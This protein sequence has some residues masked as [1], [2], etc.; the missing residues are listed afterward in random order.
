[1]LEWQ[2]AYRKLIGADVETALKRNVPADKNKPGIGYLAR[3]P[4]T[5]ACPQIRLHGPLQKLAEKG[6][7]E[8]VDFN[9]TQA[10]DY[11]I[12]VARLRNLDILIIQRNFAVAYSY[13]QLTKLLGKDR[14]LIVYEFDD[15]FDRL[16]EN[17]PGYAYYQNMKS[18]FEEYIKQADMV[19]VSTPVLKQYYSSL[20]A[21]TVVLP[22]TVNE[23]VWQ[24][25][26]DTKPKAGKATK[27]LFSGTLGHGTD[28][29]VI[30]KALQ[31]ILEEYGSKVELW[32]WGDEVPGLMQYKNVKMFESF[33]TDYREYARILKQGAFDFA[34]IP[35]APNEFNYAKSHIK[36]LEYSASGIAGVYSDIPAYKE[37]VRD[38]KTG[39]VVHNDP[40]AW[41]EAI[42]FM[43]ENPK[44]R[45]KIARAAY[46]EVWQKHTLSQNLHLW[47]E[48]YERLLRQ[49]QESRKL[50]KF[51]VVLLTWNRAQLLNLTLRALTEN[52]YFRDQTEIIV[53]DNGSTDDTP[54]VVKKYSV[55]KY[56]RKERNIGLELYKELFG[57]A[58]G[59][60]IIILD[61][62]VLDLPFAFDKTFLEYFAAFPEYGF[63]GLAVFRSEETNGGKP[64]DVNYTEEEKDGKII[65]RGPAGGWCACLSRAEFDRIN[66]FGDDALSMANTEDSI[67]NNRVIGFGKK[68]GII[69]NVRCF[70]ATGPFYSRKF[71]LLERDMEKYRMAGMQR[72]ANGYQN[73][74][75]KQKQPLVSVIIPL[76]NKLDLTRQCVRSIL[77]NTRYPR[78]EIIFVDN[79]S[80]DGTREYLKSI[81]KKE[82]RIRSILNETNAGFAIANNQGADEAN[83]KYILFLNN[84]TEVQPGWLR[85]LVDVA[86]DNPAVGAVGSKLLYPDGTLQHAGVVIVEDRQHGDPLLATHNFYKE[87]GDKPEA[88]RL[89][90][91][92]A[93]SAACLM[94]RRELF[95]QLGGFDPGFWNGYE[96]VDLCFRIAQEGYKLVYRPDSVVIHYESQSGEE[97]WKKVNQNIKRLHQKWLG[98]VQPDL[99]VDED[100]QKHITEQ[101][102]IRPYYLL[103]PA[104]SPKM[105]EEK[106]VSIIMLTYNALDFTRQAVE[107]VLQHTQYPFEIILVDNGSGKDTVQ[108]LKQVGEEY[109]NV[110]TIFNKKNKGFAAGNNQGAKSA[111]G[112]YVMFLNNDVLVSD[113]WLKSLVEA[114]QKD[115]RIGMV[116]PITNL[117]SG[118]QMV[119]DAPYTAAADFPQFAAKV[120]QINSGTLTPRRRLAGFAIL[121]P[122][123]LFEQVGGFDEEFGS[124]NYE[125]DDLCLRVRRAGYAL[126]VDEST[127][128]HHYGSQTF[129]ANKIDYNGSL[130]EKGARFKEK[131][132]EVDYEELLEIKNPLPEYELQV[133]EQAGQLMLNND[134]PAAKEA[135]E[136]LVMLNPLHVEAL[137]GAALTCNQLGEADRALGY[138]DRLNRLQ[139]NDAQVYNQIGLA[140]TLKEDT[141]GAQAAFVRAIEVDPAFVDAQ[142]NYAALLIEAGRYEDGIKAFQ[143]IVLNH[144]DD[145]PALLNLAK[146]NLEV[147]RLHDARLYL[148]KALQ[149][150][151]TN[152][153]AL[154][155]D[156]ILQERIAEHVS[157]GSG[158]IPDALNEAAELID[159]GDL[160][161]AERIYRTVI[162]NEPQ[163]PTALFGLAVVCRQLQKEDEARNLFE[164]LTRSQP[165]FTAAYNHLGQIA[166]MH[167]DY[168]Q[169]QSYFIKSLEIDPTQ[170]DTRN[171][172]SDVLIAEGEYE[173][174]INLLIHNLKD[175]P[176]D[177][178]TLLRMGIV[179]Y[180]AGK[181][182]E[183]KRY[184]SRALELQPDN[185][186]AKQY[187]QV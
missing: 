85:A 137:F 41:E 108:Y 75:F 155:L 60:H 83:G 171:F 173:N 46:K 161:E 86:E 104:L 185:D 102:G 24:P 139:P 154:E 30:A 48:A 91:Y 25:V 28:L 17:H 6:A 116:G 152:P 74:S 23:D 34:L 145:V 81:E 12:D 89:M 26:K 149:V 42:R 63:L 65:Q 14:P 31:K 181:A 109:A 183:S 158:P 132:P 32:L 76:F 77:K 174:G 172:L 64:E 71:N 68:T 55:D 163:N 93:L 57:L 66:G 90:T 118:R 159:K 176:D 127:Y 121:M 110:R 38:Y 100:G 130:E 51:S 178:E 153:A 4:S 117:I 21:N 47:R 141:E 2:N 58:E 123:A 84:D 164:Q 182:D 162:E 101:S 5:F 7:V 36:W 19:S 92:Q 113:G 27:I 114:L 115:E 157:E 144:P 88:N 111:F 136:A 112:K 168:A 70:H 61:D 73:F 107:S 80:T 78:Y 146:L 180:D 131:W 95:V 160:Q 8:F 97:R 29:E 16:P 33:H 148:N 40:E 13:G 11:Q 105:Q 119:V 22:N 59:E 124:G 94:V 120:R 175:A 126:M 170:I 87:H 35:L 72:F 166:L 138:L 50:Y 150:D 79:G 96:D 125:D 49:S 10:K 184:F 165:E 167:G 54:Q 128:I 106:M 186:V 143:Q 177:V 142:R 169:A 187:L 122:K 134:M 15:A 45:R 9:L 1:V 133:M 62:D 53:G 69:K 39:I 151:A 20:N 99:I 147:D 44:E 52:L 103:Q 82:K 135:Y 43:I 56:I 156:Q 98:K 179:H 67:L 18:N 140:F 37:A 129:K 3:E